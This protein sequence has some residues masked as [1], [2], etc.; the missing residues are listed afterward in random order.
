M[1]MAKAPKTKSV[2]YG[3]IVIAQDGKYAVRR[4]QACQR[5]GHRRDVTIASVDEVAGEDHQIGI[6]GLGQMYGLAQ[7]RRGDLTTAMQV[8]ELCNPK[9]VERLGQIRNPNSKGI[10][11]QP[12]RLDRVTI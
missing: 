9:A 2:T 3:E 12:S 10:Q 7:I 8:R 1:Q 11:F 5:L 4:L 6:L